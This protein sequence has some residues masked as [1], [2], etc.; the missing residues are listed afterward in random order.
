M[1]V[2]SDNVLLFANRGMLEMMS[3]VDVY[4]APR[5]RCKND[6]CV[7]SFTVHSAGSAS[8][9]RREKEKAGTFEFCR[10]FRVTV[11]KIAQKSRDDP[12]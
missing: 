1:I 8:W 12:T 3:T 2:S 4:G 9:C 7:M 6:V 11:T 5:R 10:S